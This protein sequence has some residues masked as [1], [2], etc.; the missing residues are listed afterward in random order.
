VDDAPFAL[1]PDLFVLRQ[2]G[3]RQ[4]LPVL[5]AHCVSTSAASKSWLESEPWATFLTKIPAAPSMVCTYRELGEDLAGRG[6]PARGALWREII[7]TLQ[8]PRGYVAFWP[9]S[10]LEG[11]EYL[12]K[13]DAFVEGLSRMRPKTLLVFDASPGDG[14]ASAMLGLVRDALPGLHIL[15]IPLSST[16]TGDDTQLV[17][18]IASSVRLF[19]QS[20]S[21]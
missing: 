15:T 16:L 19:L 7:R 1:S 20:I 2:A 8:L 18:E 4:V 5:N 13:S 3:I 12:L 11:N 21:G 17:E 6:N 14:S 10:L 9:H